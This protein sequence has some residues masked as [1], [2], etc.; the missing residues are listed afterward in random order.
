MKP[1]S[2][3]RWLDLLKNTLVVAIV[4]LLLITP[5]LTSEQLAQIKPGMTMKDATNL[6]GEPRIVK[7]MLHKALSTGGFYIGG[8]LLPGEM[9]KPT[10]S[11][12][13]PWGTIKEKSEYRTS[14]WMG[15]THL[16]WVEHNNGIVV[17]TWLF[18]ITR[19]GGGLQGCID[20]IKQYWND[21]RK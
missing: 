17:N 20:T 14:T 8:W 2:Y 5:E 15:K 7:A 18:P 9:W 4:V 13:I 10:L 12:E 3:N 1:P 19:T 16:L 21:W 11:A 6:L